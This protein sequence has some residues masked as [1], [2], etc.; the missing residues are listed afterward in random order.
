VTRKPLRVIFDVQTAG[1]VGTIL[2]GVGRRSWMVD[3]R[4]CGLVVDAILRVI[5][6]VACQEKEERWVD[7][8]VPGLGAAGFVSRESQSKSQE[9]PL[10]DRI[11]EVYTG[12]ELNHAG[13]YPAD[14]VVRQ[15]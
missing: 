14:L 8:T 4:E 12:F 2:A 15:E 5:A 1:L 9:R 7:V 13:Y 6:V 10:P 3:E 11:A